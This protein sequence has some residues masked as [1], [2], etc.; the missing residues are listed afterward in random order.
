MI[1]IKFKNVLSHK[2][3][4][5]S[6]S[7]R[8]ILFSILLYEIFLLKVIFFKNK[9]IVSNESVKKLPKE[10]III[11][12]FLVDKYFLFLEYISLISSS[13]LINRFDWIST[14]F[15]IIKLKIIRI[16]EI[17][18]LTK[19]LIK[20]IELYIKCFSLSIMISDIISELIDIIFKI[21]KNKKNALYISFHKPFF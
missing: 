9:I 4:D 6:M 3:Y 10:I 5:I 18:K 11:W 14:I 1:A 12:I 15:Q 19:L 7:K 2:L 20:S 13:K 8:F 16:M 21:A 17:N